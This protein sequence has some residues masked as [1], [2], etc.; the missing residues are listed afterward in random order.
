[1]HFQLMSLLCLLLAMLIFT[2]P[3]SESR[4]RSFPFYLTVSLLYVLPKRAQT[5]SALSSTTRNAKTALKH[6]I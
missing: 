6:N 1:M 4:Q 5:R 3:T 2:Q